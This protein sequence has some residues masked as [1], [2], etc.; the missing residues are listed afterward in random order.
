MKQIDLMFRTMIAELQ[1]RAFDDVWAEDFRPTGR[2][3]SVPVDGRKYWYFD[4]PNGEGGQ[5][6]RYVGP[7]DDTEI[8]ARVETFKGE[9]S[10]YKGRRKLVSTLTREAGLIA[11]DRFTGAVVEALAAAG[12]FRL[13]CVL[14]GTVA[15]QCYAPFLGIRLP[16][17]AIL[18]GDADIA[19]D[20]AISSEVSDSLPPILD[21][22]KGIDDSFR[23]LPHISG[24]PRSN[25]FRNQSGYRV[26]FLTTNR[27]AEE[28]A[29][30]PAQMP[31]LGG[32]SAEPLR[33]MDFLIRDPVRSILLHGAGVSVV[34][35]DPSRFAV[36]KPIVGGRR[37]DDTGGRAKRDKD[38]RQA[39]MLFEALQQVGDGANLADALREAW[40]RGPSWRT[41]LTVSSDRVPKEYQPAVWRTF[42]LLS[43]EDTRKAPQAGRDHSRGDSG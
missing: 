14:V 1:Q 11:P 22:L 24:S 23:A 42:G 2:F 15:F 27:R 37:L 32:A 4:E 35:P 12:L 19:Q 30:Q 34:V 29:D 28:Y 36:H 10:D 16:M 39:G 25:A 9:K 7:E 8:S 43:E 21:L 17:A 41:A 40:D 3:V 38:L 6:R 33:Y 20:Y 5:K 31:A 26:E 18:T 13:R